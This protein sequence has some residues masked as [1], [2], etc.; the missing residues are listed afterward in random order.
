MKTIRVFSLLLKRL[1][2]ELLGSSWS[3]QHCEESPQRPPETHP[4]CAL[5]LCGGHMHAQTTNV[6]S[7]EMLLGFGYRQPQGR[8]QL[9]DEEV[10]RWGGQASFYT[11][12]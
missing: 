7:L 12:P 10:P 8:G 9:W 2:Q 3:G 11:A 5:C 4:L 6:I 1:Q